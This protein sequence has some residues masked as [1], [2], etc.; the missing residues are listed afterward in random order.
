MEDVLKAFGVKRGDEAQ[1]SRLVGFIGK[2]F[3]SN[4]IN[5]KVLSDG[6]V[7]RRSVGRELFNPTAVIEDMIDFVQLNE[8]IY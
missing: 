8:A 4:G 6:S 5:W 3:E 1:V 2:A 7:F